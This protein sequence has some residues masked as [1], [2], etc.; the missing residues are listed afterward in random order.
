M[1]VKAKPNL[2]TPL[3]LRKKF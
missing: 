1:S 3:L 2:F